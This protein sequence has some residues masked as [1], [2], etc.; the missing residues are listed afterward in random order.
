MNIDYIILYHRKH[1]KLY[2]SYNLTIIVRYITEKR[3][4][5][6]TDKSFVFII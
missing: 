4:L 3:T 6:T 5:A 2:V 1:I